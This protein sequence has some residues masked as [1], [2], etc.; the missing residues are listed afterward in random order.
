MGAK[1][2]ENGFILI[3]ED[4]PDTVTLILRA[5][6]KCGVEEEVVVARDGAEALTLLLEPRAEASRRPCFVLLDLNLPKLSGHDVLTRLRADSRTSLLPV[7]VFSSSGMDSDVLASYK[8]GAN[9]YVYKPVDFAALNE[10]IRNIAH[11]WLRLNR[12]AD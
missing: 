10:T 12:K 9:S 2:A 4:N 6:K 5:L 1:V 11:Y 7:V 3:V 8:L